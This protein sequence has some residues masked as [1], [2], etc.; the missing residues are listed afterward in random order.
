MLRAVIKDG[1]GVV[2]VTAAP[3]GGDRVVVVMLIYHPPH[4]S[5]RHTPP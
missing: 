4:V 1:K 3:V 2:G 5:R